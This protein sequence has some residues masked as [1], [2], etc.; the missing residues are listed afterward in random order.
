MSPFQHPGSKLKKLYTSIFLLSLLG[1]IVAAV[2]VS[3]H[4][5]ASEAGSFCNLDD[6]WNCDR[7]NKSTFAQIFNIPVSIYGLLF[8]SFLSFITFGLI[9]GWNFTKGL[10]PLKFNWLPFLALLGSSAVTI[11]LLYYES[12]ILGNLA[13]I[14]IVKN[15]VFLGLYF[16]IFRFSQKNPHPTVHFMAFLAIS[17]LFGVNFSLYL[18]EVELLVLE[19]ICIFCLTQQIIIIMISVLAV[20]TL[21]QNKNEY[22]AKSTGKLGST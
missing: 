10:F 20:I 21:K 16:L 12:T 19:A 7:V 2:L 11:F 9:K 18:S 8:Y 3:I 1:A 4:F 15:L 14:G 5:K 13:Y 17:A 6:Y 22:T